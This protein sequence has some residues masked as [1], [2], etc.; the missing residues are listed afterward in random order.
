MSKQKRN[1]YRL[2]GLIRC[3]KQPLLI[4][5][6]P[7]SGRVF[8][9]RADY[10]TFEHDPDNDIL[11]LIEFSEFSPYVCFLDESDQMEISANILT[12]IGKVTSLALQSAT[13]F[14]ESRRFPSELKRE[15]LQALR[16]FRSYFY[17]ARYFVA[18]IRGLVAQI[19]KHIKAYRSFNANQAQANLVS[20]FC[21]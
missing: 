5:R 7:E 10:K 13:S 17:N 12:L 4:L 14:G 8:I 19:W 9:R 21:N 11:T 18:K 1:A 6:N 20:E 2:E 15:Y 16:Y 3:P